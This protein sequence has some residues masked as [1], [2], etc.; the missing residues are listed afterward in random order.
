M[1]DDI[2]YVPVNADYIR[3]IKEL[4][5]ALNE[6]ENSRNCGLVCVCREDFES[7]WVC[8]GST[9]GKSS[10]CYKKFQQSKNLNSMIRFV[11]E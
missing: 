7:A 2:Q 4:F 1:N 11:F 8:V 3:G 10:P 5:E 6:K 9:N